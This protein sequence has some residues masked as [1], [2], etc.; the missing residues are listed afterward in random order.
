MSSSTLSSS[1]GPWIKSRLRKRNHSD[2]E[3]TQEGSS[4]KAK[5]SVDEANTKRDSKDKK[6]RQRK[7]KKKH[8]IV[9]VQDGKARVRDSRRGTSM[10]L[11]VTPVASPMKTR[12]SSRGRSKSAV[13]EPDTVEDITEELDVEEI[14]S[15]SKVRL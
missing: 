5:T 7:K 11:E 10:T 6:K 4:K 1:P 13:P 3:D 15:S 8:S 12:E 9:I 14:V 2:D